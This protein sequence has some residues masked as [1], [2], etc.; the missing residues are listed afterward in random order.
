MIRRAPTLA[1]PLL[2]S[3]LAL[4]ASPLAAA[5]S[6]LRRLKGEARIAALRS[7]ERQA[8]IA[9]A[10]WLGRAGDRDRAVLA[11]IEAL[12]NEADSEVRAAIADA[13]ARRR[14]PRAIEVLAADAPGILPAERD[15][16]LRAL[17][18]I[19][20][21]A[22]R[23]ALAAALGGPGASSAL[24]RVIEIGAPILEDVVPLLDLPAAAVQAARALGAIGDL[25]GAE[26]LAAH[27]Q[28]PSPELR[29]AVLEALGAIGD[30]QSAPLALAALGD[31][32][33]IVVRAALVALARLGTADASASIAPLLGR[34]E[35]ELRAAALRALA[36]VDPARAAGS[37]ADALDE[38]PRE[39]LTATLSPP[40]L[41][42]AAI[43]ALLDAPDRALLAPLRMLARDPAHRLAALDAIARI[44]R[45]AG[46]DALIEEAAAERAGDAHAALAIALR[47]A[48]DLDPAMRQ[49]AFEVLRREPDPD[50]ALMLG[51]IA[52][53]PAAEPAILAALSNGPSARRVIAARALAI[54]GAA[55]AERSL[56]ALEHACAAER[57]PI[58]LEA[59]LRTLAEAGG[60]IDA[61]R[62]LA[63]DP[64]AHPIARALALSIAR[65]ASSPALGRVIR[66][67]LR[68]G[69]H[70][71][72]PRAR[73][74]AVESLARADARGAAMA[75]AAAVEDPSPE[76]RLAAAH[77]LRELGAS[78][79]PEIASR[80]AS[81]LAVES[82]ARVRH[83]LR[84]ALERPGRLRVRGDECL[85][86]R[87][88]RSAEGGAAVELVLADGRWL[89][90]PVLP[91]GE[92]VVCDLPAGEADVRLSP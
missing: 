30:E 48:P 89:R 34:R 7:G 28:D 83:A 69:L 88:A 75:I 65:P 39:A 19:D 59:I 61:D 5:D 44:A 37:I 3:A 81:R 47:R 38:R 20:G 32:E 23:A 91:T 50:R 70:A 85:L 76:V 1:A 6:W 33:P 92:V 64:E 80:L 79:R 17:A 31:S 52:R 55:G 45:G 35:P 63:L 4:C 15:A 56:A 68:A 46:I 49:R 21:S 8:R 87:L 86:V 71:S 2:A 16:R 74:V 12:E 43:D 18:A 11:M 77:A 13:L 58:A 24:A 57:E 26:A 42:E 90:E 27:A 10:R 54:F 78:E 40:S 72:D 66:V 22:A 60:R 14:D 82:D 53:D 51:A 62:A 41:R 67:A 36:Q 84:D 9:A 29:A 25:R 73:A